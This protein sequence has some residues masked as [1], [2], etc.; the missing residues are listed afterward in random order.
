MLPMF[1]QL[2]VATTIPTLEKLEVVDASK[3]N[4]GQLL[5][6]FHVVKKGVKDL[7]AAL[8]DRTKD[9]SYSG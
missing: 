8:E 4:K 7:L 6:A 2:K 5:D 9:L 3:L 1:R